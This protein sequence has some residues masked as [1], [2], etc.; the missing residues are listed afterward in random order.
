MR[1]LL[2]RKIVAQNGIC[3]ICLEEFTDYG[4]IVPYA[5]VGIMQ[6][7]FSSM[8]SIFSSAVRLRGSMVS[9][10]PGSRAGELKMDWTEPPR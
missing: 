3:A 10:K 6:S 1:K 5:D 8:Q 2:K 9:E 4:D 7:I